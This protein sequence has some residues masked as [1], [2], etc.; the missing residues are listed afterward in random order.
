MIYLQLYYLPKEDL[1]SY[2]SM[3]Y[4]EAGGVKRTFIFQY[5]NSCHWGIS[6]GLMREEKVNSNL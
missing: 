4:L 2:H 1:A 3:A 6:R 5:Y